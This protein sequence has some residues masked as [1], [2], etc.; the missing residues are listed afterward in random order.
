MSN[1]YAEK[2]EYFKIDLFPDGMTC[3]SCGGKHFH[4]TATILPRLSAKVDDPKGIDGKTN[5]WVARS[6]CLAKHCNGFLDWTF[7][8]DYCGGDEKGNAF[9]SQLTWTSNPLGL[10]MF[11]NY[12]RS[13]V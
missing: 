1:N 5:L 4:P 13:K 8:P 10:Q 2:H 3:P 6:E 11:K 12:P 7:H 9:R